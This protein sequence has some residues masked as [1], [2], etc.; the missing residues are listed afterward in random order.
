MFYN[1]RNIIFKNLLVFM[2]VLTFTPLASAGSL[3]NHVFASDLGINIF[4]W[5]K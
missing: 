4:S 3:E 1:L 2:F 5:C